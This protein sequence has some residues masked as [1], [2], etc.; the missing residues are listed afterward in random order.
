ML[1][2]L[3]VVIFIFFDDTKGY[4][5]FDNLASYHQLTVK[6][7][8]GNDYVAGTGHNF[9]TY[10]GDFNEVV[11]GAV[12][13]HFWG[14]YVTSGTTESGNINIWGLIDGQTTMRSYYKFGVS[15]PSAVCRHVHLVTYDSFVQKW[16]IITGDDDADHNNFMRF[17]YDSVA[18][19]IT[20]E[21]IGKGGGTSIWENGGMAFAYY[22][23]RLS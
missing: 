23:S 20:A 21:I 17:T 16:Y 13:I 14:P 6:G 15:S 1:L 11:A 12:K 10:G 18:D 2:F 22:Y 19:T 7:I 5:S 9:R 3:K 4:Y 8:D